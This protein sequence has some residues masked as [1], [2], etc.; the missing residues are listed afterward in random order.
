TP[1]QRHQLPRV[2]DQQILVRDRLLPHALQQHPVLLVLPQL[3]PPGAHGA[4]PEAGE[5]LALQPL[6]RVELAHGG[7]LQVEELA[8]DVGEEGEETGGV[9]ELRVDG[10]L[11]R[12]Q[13][14]R[15]GAL[16]RQARLL[17]R[18]AR[19]QRREDEVEGRR[20]SAGGVRVREHAQGREEGV[21]AVQGG[22]ERGGRGRGECGELA[23]RPFHHQDN[24]V[25]VA[26]HRREEVGKLVRETLERVGEVVE[27]GD[28]ERRGCHVCGAHALAQVPDRGPRF[29]QLVDV[30]DAVFA[31]VD[32][33]LEGAREGGDLDDVGEGGLAG[34]VG[35][36]A[37]TEEREHDDGEAC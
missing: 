24:V 14:F 20:G 3:G 5:H 29:L 27:L 34:G 9:R 12:G 18:R 33:R 28:D 26:V 11:Q 19:D 4:H 25:D 22:R 1:L 7:A 6:L 31:V 8:V 2:L 15:E 36:Q 16:E 30:R 32:H 37:E 10:L 13:E 23:L 17:G 21:Q 35:E